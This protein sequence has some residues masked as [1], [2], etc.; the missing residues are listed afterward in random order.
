M[1]LLIVLFAFIVS[2]ATH[3]DGLSLT[4]GKYATS[5]ITVDNDLAQ[6]RAV[7]MGM[8]DRGRMF[9]I[10]GICNG[11][12]EPVWTYQFPNQPNLEVDGLAL[13]MFKGLDNFDKVD[14]EEPGPVHPIFDTNYAISG[15]VDLVKLF[16]GTVDFDKSDQSMRFAWVGYKSSHDGTKV[17]VTTPT[18][19]AE[20][21]FLMTA[22]LADYAKSTL[23]SCDEAAKAPVHVRYNT[24]K[25]QTGK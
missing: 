1:R 22:G 5:S 20:E 8:D 3:A 14:L 4:A 15:T 2:I 11:D 13:V 9:S 19:T 16:R 7:W 17:V 10:T 12:Q 25:S 6:M 23:Q 21:M 18:M 24:L